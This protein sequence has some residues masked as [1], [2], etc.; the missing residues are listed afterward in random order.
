MRFI[1]GALLCAFVASPA[2]AEWWEAETEHFIV[3]SDT[4]DRQARELAVRLER[5]DEAMRFLQ[6]MK[7]EEQALPRAT[8][9]TLYHFGSV[10][11]IGRLYSDRGSPVA[12]F[13]MARAGNSVAFAPV[14]DESRSARN[15]SMQRSSR[16]G[17]QFADAVVLHE[18]AHYFMFQ[19]APAAY[20]AWYTE[21]FAEVYSTLVMNDDG[22]RIGEPPTHRGAVLDYYAAYPVDRLLN[23]PPLEERQQRD[24]MQLYGLGYL[25]AHYL[26]F[27]GERP[28]QLR[29]Y[30][31][32][33]NA[34]S[35][36]REAAEGAFGDLDQL[37]KEMD[38]YRTRSRLPVRDITFDDYELPDVETRRLNEADVAQMSLQIQSQ[39]GV[40]KERA[41]ELVPEARALATRY[42]DSA[43][44][45][46]T[47]TEAEFDADNLAEAEAAARRV[48]SIDPQ[49]AAA[50]LFLARIAMERGEDDPAQY[51][52]A[53]DAYVTANRLEPRNPAVLYGIYRTYAAAGDEMPKSAIEALDEAQYLAGFDDGI[54]LELASMQLWLGDGP[55]AV[56]LLG[57]LLHDPHRLE[58]GEKLKAVV[59][60]IQDGDLEAAS[61]RLE[62]YGQDDEEDD[63]EEA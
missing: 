44:V 26:T 40:S 15:R 46:L 56:E 31:D 9:L 14:E 36:E 7:D 5:F 34:G 54:R 18:Y 8:K 24:N 16:S 17:D 60:A 37:D 2:A 41:A 45:M 53:R 1:V 55:F 10:D 12:G 29:Q 57:P 49:S 28:G 42:P 39:R 3:Y 48:L 25:L 4:N 30:L 6:G 63:E 23:P 21:G 52:V 35:T 13:F 58:R 43:R 50:H 33:I 61:Q 47:V 20:P 11:D 19:H 59:A 38:A 32:L 51:A 27:S 22:F 62:A